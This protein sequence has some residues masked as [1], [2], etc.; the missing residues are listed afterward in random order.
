M[1]SIGTE[2]DPEIHEAI[3]QIP[4]QDDESKGKIIDEV[5]KGYYLYEKV[6]RHAKV[7]VA[8]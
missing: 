8:I 3:A 7:V 5:V 2:F 4:A 6:I 1:E